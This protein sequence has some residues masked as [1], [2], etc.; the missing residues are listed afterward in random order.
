MALI[1]PKTNYTGSYACLSSLISSLPEFQLDL[2]R[3]FGM[4]L[5]G[6]VISGPIMHAAY[7]YFEH[8]IPTT[9]NNLISPSAAAILHMFGD[10]FVLDAFFVASDMV[11]SGLMEGYG[12]YE[13]IVPR[14]C[15]DY[16]ILQN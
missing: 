13:D 6:F 16:V 3:A 7:D 12:F 14:L 9:E 11:S 15:N 4:F 5:D 1:M 2:R 10:I 8:I